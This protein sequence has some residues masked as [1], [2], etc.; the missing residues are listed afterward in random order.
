M[1]QSCYDDHKWCF[2]RN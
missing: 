2:E 1:W